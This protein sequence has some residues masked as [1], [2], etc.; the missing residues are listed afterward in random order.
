MSSSAGDIDARSRFQNGLLGW[1]RGAAAQDSASGL[2]EMIAVTRSLSGEGNAIAETSGDSLLWR[3]ATSFLQALLDGS[4]RAD[5]EARTVCKR[6]ERHLAGRGVTPDTRPQQAAELANAIFA[7][8]SNR[9]HPAEPD[10]MPDAQTAD[11]GFGALLSNTLTSTAEL[12]PLLGSSQPARRLDDAQLQRWRTATDR[13]TTDWHAVKTGALAHCRDAALALVSLA[14]ELADASSLQLAEAFADAAGAGERLAVRG[15]PAFRAAFDAAL[16]VAVHPEGP[17]QKGFDR[18][19]DALADRLARSAVPPKPD[20]VRVSERN[21]WFAEDACEVLAELTAAL[22]A[23]PPKRLALLAG[24]DWF[25]QHDQGKAIAIRG[26]A[27]TAHRIIGQI[28]TDDLDEAATHHTVAQSI[29]ALQTA[30]THFSAGHAPHPDEAVFAA[31]RAL[32]ARCAEQRQQAIAA[33]RA[34]RSA[35]A[36]EPGAPD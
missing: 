7:F 10:V 3:S 4:L 32:E 17:D 22:D 13:L 6:L 31:L 30:V 36:A 12:L 27:T 8:V 21:P 20:A 23:V 28:R 34:A 15:S 16:E 11:R 25:I 24:F 29:K 35:T 33:A 26:L 18:L 1:L 9:S 19:A 5:E 14:L 2:R